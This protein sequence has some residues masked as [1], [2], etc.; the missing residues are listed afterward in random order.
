MSPCQV[1]DS[2]PGPLIKLAHNASGVISKCF[3]QGEHLDN[4]A[5]TIEVEAGP[6]VGAVATIVTGTHFVPA[7]VAA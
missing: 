5:Y 7:Q 1:T 4:L 3:S 6:G 2:S